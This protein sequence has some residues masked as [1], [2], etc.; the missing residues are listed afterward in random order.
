MRSAEFDGTHRILHLA[1]GGE[2]KARVVTS[3]PVLR[4]FQYQFVDGF[5][6]P[7]RL[8]LGTLDLLEDGADTLVIYSQQIE[9]DEL[10]DIVGRAVV[11]G[12]EGIRRRFSG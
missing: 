8:H 3:D 5:P 7:V 2:L 9:P 12:I 11:G 4:R 1:D 6:V 10:G